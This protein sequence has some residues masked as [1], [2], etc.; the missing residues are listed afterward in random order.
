[1][2]F[3]NKWVVE[4]IISKNSEENNIQMRELTMS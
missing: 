3:F 4:E 1:M 2:V